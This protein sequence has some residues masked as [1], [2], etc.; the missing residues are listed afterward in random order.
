MCVI[1]ESASSS[2]SHSLSF[3]PPFFVF[4]S[5]QFQLSP[6]AAR[7]QPSS[8]CCSPAAG[9]G[10]AAGAPLRLFLNALQLIWASHG[11]VADSGSRSERI[12]AKSIGCSRNGRRRASG[13]RRRCRRLGSESETVKRGKKCAR[14]RA[15]CSLR[16]RLSPLQRAR[17]RRWPEERKASADRK[18]AL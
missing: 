14:G 15:V 8:N 10:R 5:L 7:A 13:R 2:S 6:L 16:A 17:V 1:R 9:S 18:R 3:L 4:S 11:L 12:H